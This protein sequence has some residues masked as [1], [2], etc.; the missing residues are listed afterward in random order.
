MTRR[1][2]IASLRECERRIAP[3]ECATVSALAPEWGISPGALARRLHRA[4]VKLDERRADQRGG[5]RQSGDDC[6]IIRQAIA[7]ANTAAHPGEVSW[8]GMAAEL[9][10]TTRAKDPGRALRESVRAYCQ[11]ERLPMPTVGRGRWGRR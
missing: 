3:P 2:T 8:A 9:G 4:G 5:A 10:W 1:W 7:R 6:A 11:R